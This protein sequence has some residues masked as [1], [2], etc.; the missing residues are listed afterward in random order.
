MPRKQAHVE[1]WGIMLDKALCTCLNHDDER[2]TCAHVEM[3][4]KACKYREDDNSVE[5]EG[6]F[7]EK[8][9]TCGDDDAESESESVQMLG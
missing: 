1:K 4:Q 9:Y 5:S 7:S 8:V 6:H 3:K 2:K